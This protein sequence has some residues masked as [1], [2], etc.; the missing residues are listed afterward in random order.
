M[1]IAELDV[2]II[3]I[4]VNLF[5]LLRLIISDF[6]R[7]VSLSRRAYRLCREWLK[8]VVFGDRLSR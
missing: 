1:H 6:W 3:E 5:L 8:I 2:E 4:P 7:P